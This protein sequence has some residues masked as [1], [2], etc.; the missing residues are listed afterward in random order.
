MSKKHKDDISEG[1]LSVLGVLGVTWLGVEI[2]KSF[3]KKEVVYDC[4]VCL[5]SVKYGVHTCSN[6]NSILDWPK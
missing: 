3:S 5:Y 4:P 1:I 6:C 2:L